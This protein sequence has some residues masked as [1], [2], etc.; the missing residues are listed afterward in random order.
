M[1][2]WAFGVAGVATVFA[3]AGFIIWN[4]DLGVANSATP[5]M[6][7]ALYAA[8]VAFAIGI[9]AAIVAVIMF[10]IALKDP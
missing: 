1:G 10:I 9:V 7:Q 3:F 2:A 5:G 6:A 4:V 8:N